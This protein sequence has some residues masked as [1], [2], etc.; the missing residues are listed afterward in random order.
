[1]ASRNGGQ[2]PRQP[3]VMRGPVV[4]KGKDS[5]ASINAG[6]PVVNE[7]IPPRQV[8]LHFTSDKVLLRGLQFGG[9]EVKQSSSK[10][11]IRRFR[12]HYGVGAEACASIFNDLYATVIPTDENLREFLMTMNWLKCYPTEGIMAGDWNLNEKTIRTKVKV[13]SQSIAALKAKKILF[14]NFEDDDVFVVSVDGI[15][16]NIYEPRKDPSSKWY[17]HKSNSAGLTYELAIA[18]RSNRLV[19]IR[20]PFPASQHDM[21]TFRGGQVNEVKNANALQFQIPEG[22]R[23]IGDSGYRGEPSKISVSQPKDSASVRNFKSR[24]KARHET[25]NARLKSFKILSTRFRHKLSTD[26]LVEHQVV[27]EAVCVACQYDMENDHGLFEV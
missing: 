11:N 19:W 16:C 6:N 8:A 7:A 5:R 13:H 9:F 14:G 17:S 26:T 2:A 18:I 3:V 4:A 22:K 24:V 21:T 15:H 12:E 23:A 20:G 10:L 1:M 25:F 27:F